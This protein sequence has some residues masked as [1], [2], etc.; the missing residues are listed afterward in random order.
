MMPSRITK[1][2]IIVNVIM[3]LL[4]FLSS[5]LVLLNLK[6]FIVEEVNIFSI[7]T[8]FPYSAGSAPVPTIRIQPSNFPFYVFLAFL[9]INTY[10]MIK[11]RRSKEKQLNPIQVF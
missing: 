2:I 9:I 3:G 6:G 1:V 10:F 4:L 8:G 5:Q 7:S 11:L